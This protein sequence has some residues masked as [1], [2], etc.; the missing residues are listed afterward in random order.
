MILVRV[1]MVH[2]L[3]K[4]VDAIDYQLPMPAG[5]THSVTGVTTRAYRVGQQVSPV[6]PSIHSQERGPLSGCG[7]QLKR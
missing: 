2:L 1:G 4:A 7:A 6:R 3:G 5:G